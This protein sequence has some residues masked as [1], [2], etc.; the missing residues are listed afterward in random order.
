[1]KINQL[2]QLLRDNARTDARPPI[3][4]QATEEGVAIYV[5]DVI[6]P[7]WGAS[8]TALIEQLTAAAGKLVELHINS[9]GGDV[10]EARAMAAAIAGY[11]G[12]VEACIDGVCASAATYLAL[13]AKSTCMVEGALL[14]VHNSWT[15]AYGDKTA[16]RSTAD[17]VEKIDGTIAATYMKKTGATLA[18]VQAWM[19]AE[20]WFTCQEAL[21]A[22]F[23]DAIEPN[24]QQGDM[25]EDAQQNRWNLSAYANAP[26]PQ[27]R[28]A[29]APD[30]AALAAELAAKAATQHQANRNRLR[31]FVPI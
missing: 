8:A 19:D 3:R 23:I 18:Q 31:L 30:P 26:K 1:M 15:I 2:M 4:A 7:Y 9:P 12:P 25:A 13:A 20:T 29:P 28:A 5:Y 16:L 27:P 11:D 24:T 22:H 17:L 6:D 14:M 21:D 10:F